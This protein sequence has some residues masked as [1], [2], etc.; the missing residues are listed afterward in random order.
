MRQKYFNKMKNY[1][2]K[3]IKEQKDKITERHQ[4]PIYVWNEPPDF[5]DKKRY[6]PSDSDNSKNRGY[7]EVSFDI[8]DFVIKM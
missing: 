5:Q 4:I 1:I 6:D 8:D 3:K 2:Y 7:E